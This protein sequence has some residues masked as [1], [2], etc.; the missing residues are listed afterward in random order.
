MTAGQP[1]TDL[2][3]PLPAPPA[4]PHPAARLDEVDLQLLSALRADGRVRASALAR[5]LQLSEATVGSRLR[6]LADSGVLTGV[7][8]EVDPGALGRPLQAIA[9]VTHGPVPLDFHRLAARLPAVQSG[10]SLA[11]DAD[12]EL[13]LACADQH[14]L[15]AVVAELRLAGAA[16]VQVELVLRRLLPEAPA[17]PIAAVTAVTAVTAASAPQLA[18]SAV[19]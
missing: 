5:R 6:R 11:G 2:R 10:L 19:A 3:G 1:A 15:H 4:A 7:H 12:L 13:H 9:R 17:L 18:R 14:E 16:R 8:A